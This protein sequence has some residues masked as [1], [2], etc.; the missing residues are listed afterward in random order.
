[1]NTIYPNKN[2]QEREIAAVSFLAQ[3]GEQ[4]LEQ[5]R[6]AIQPTCLGHHVLNI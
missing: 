5:I 3:Y 4:L 6:E 2:L 1:V